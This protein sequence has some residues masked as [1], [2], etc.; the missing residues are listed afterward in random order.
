[1]AKLGVAVVYL[2]LFVKNGVTVFKCM[3][4]KIQNLKKFSVKFLQ[5]IKISLLKFMKGEFFIERFLP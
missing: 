3:Q 4:N 2:F 5:E 1:M